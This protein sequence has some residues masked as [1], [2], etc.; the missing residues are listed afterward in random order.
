MPSVEIP[1]GNHCSFRKIPTQVTDQKF[2]IG[3]SDPHRKFYKYLKFPNLNN[4]TNENNNVVVFILGIFE[5]DI[6]KNNFI[7]GEEL[8]IISEVCLET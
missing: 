7:C 1:Y 4:T 8:Q 6:R 2:F 3:L 5:V